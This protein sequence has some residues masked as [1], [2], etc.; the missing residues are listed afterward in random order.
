[1]K[2]AYILIILLILLG[3]YL[4][5]QSANT[6]LEPVGRLAFVKV[7]NPDIYPGHPNS[8][9]LADYGAKKGS[10]SVLVVHFGGSSNYRSYMEG[11]IQIIELAFVDS[12]NYTTDIN[13]SE[14]FSSFILGVPDDKYKYKADGIY[15]DTYDEAM[16]Y[17]RT[18]A[19]NK[20]QEGSIPVF[21]H[22]T[23]RKGDPFINP[24]CGFPLYVEICWKE[25]GRIGAYYYIVKGMMWP[26]LSNPYAPYQISHI[27]D[28]QDKYNEGLLDYQ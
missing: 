5:I 26:Y 17:V 16:N 11:D 22:G 2:K 8:K 21:F 14:V 12:G 18:L 10:K 23:V 27:N 15:F 7:A 20:G 1:M 19:A 13:W 6:D 24:G 4:W 25:Y 3:S 28:L 9:V